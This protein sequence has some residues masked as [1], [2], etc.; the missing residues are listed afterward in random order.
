MTAPTALKMAGISKEFRLAVIISAHTYRELL[1][2]SNTHILNQN[3]DSIYQK[4]FASA[5]FDGAENGL[6]EYKGQ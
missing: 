6:K 2:I 4:D 5:I 1:Q 3:W